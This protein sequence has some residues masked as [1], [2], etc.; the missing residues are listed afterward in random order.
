M[1][2]V[3]K[4]FHQKWNSK[5]FGDQRKNFAPKS[6]E[7]KGNVILSKKICT[8]NGQEIFLRPGHFGGNFFLSNSHFLSFQVILEQ[9]IFL[10]PKVFQSSIEKNLYVLLIQA[11]FST[12]LW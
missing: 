6:P 12:L 5:N 4:Y 3:L 2:T 7:M 10:P 8:Q 9:K 1:K 11:F